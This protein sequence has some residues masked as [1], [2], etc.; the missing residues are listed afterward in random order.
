MAEILET[1]R[2]DHA[3]MAR[4][5]NILE[6]QVSAFGGGAAPDYEIVQGV[7][8]YFLDYPDLCHHPIDD[9]L[10]RTLLDKSEFK[11]HA[12]RG[13]A[14]QHEELGVLTRRFAEV[15]RRVIDEAELPRD[16]FIRAA[17]EFISSQRHHM[18]ME[19]EYFF[20]L[21]EGGLTPQDLAALDSEL[22]DKEDP[23]FGDKV[24]GRFEAL[25]N[26][27][28]TWERAEQED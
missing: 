11:D 14:E 22:F 9:L 18:Q 28:V 25:L 21:A 12:I 15:V 8:D 5:L 16:Y 4:L 13:L 20:P 1:L 3:N 7:V 10:A 24:K 23:L 2:R 19:E 27:I 6:K 26:D 17:K